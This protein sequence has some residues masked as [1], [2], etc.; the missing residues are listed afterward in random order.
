MSKVRKVLL[1]VVLIAV[2]SIVGLGLIAFLILWSWSPGR[3][4]PFLGENGDVLAGSISEIVRTKIGDIEQGMIIRG[5]SLDNP[6][7]LYLHGGPGTPTFVGGNAISLSHLEDYFIVVYWEQRGA[8]MSYHSAEISRGVTVEQLVSDTVEVAN[9]LRERFEQDTIFLMG[10]SW[11]SFL[12]MQ[13]IAKHPEIFTAY[14]GIA[15]VVYGFE[16]EVLAQT[17]ILEASIENNDQRTFNRV[18][19]HTL[20]SHEDITTSWLT[21][22]SDSLN[23]L[24]NGVIH[25]QFSLF[26]LLIWPFFTAREYTLS[27]KFG[28]MMGNLHALNSPAQATM[29][30]TNLM[31][32]ITKIDVPI[33]IF[34]G[35]HDKQVSYELSRRYFDILGA[36]E[37]HF[38][39][40]YNSAHSPAMEEPKKFIEII[41]RYVLP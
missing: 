15:Q 17:H 7:L 26:R 31:E 13:T 4:E 36:P 30:R 9:Y 20:N 16:S 10:H 28:F 38:F 8:G 6:V 24:G 29:V 3:I 5:R 40:F 25:E 23:T 12:G 21:L 27:D 2:G 19:A 34:H 37:K 22:R 33:F 1:K 39:T 35:I 14:L 18:S 41:V 11:G 32:E